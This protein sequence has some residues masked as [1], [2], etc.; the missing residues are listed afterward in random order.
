MKRFQRALVVLFVTACCSLFGQVATSSISGTVTDNTGATVMGA[1]VTAVQTETNFTRTVQTDKLGQY[2][3]LSLPLGPYR[4]GVNASGFKK[5]EQSGVVLDIDRNARV[6]A[7]LE[8]GEI[9]QTISVA[10][11]A[12]QVNTT[13]ATLGRTV[14]NREILNL[15]LVNRDVYTLLTLT[16][17]VDSVK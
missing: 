15:P 16:P 3:L 7:V 1:S 2:Q 5:F 12:A 13:D 10:A 14:E 9:S 17:G 8:V 11:D 4:V 6:D